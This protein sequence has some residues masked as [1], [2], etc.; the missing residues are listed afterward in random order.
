MTALSQND[1]TVVDRIRWYS[2]ERESLLQLAWQNP[3]I[4]QWQHGYSLSDVGLS[5][6]LRHED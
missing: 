5:W 6:Q 4:K 1:T 3:A 2:S